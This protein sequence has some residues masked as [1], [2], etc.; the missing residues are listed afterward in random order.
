[1]SVFLALIGGM[2]GSAL[3]VIIPPLLHLRVIVYSNEAIQKGISK[4][5]A[6]K[7][8]L[9]ILVGVFL[10]VISTYVSFVELLTKLGETEASG[11]GS[12]SLVEELPSTT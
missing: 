9:I 5:H 4:F 12:S 7:D 10:G 8:V 1:M 6:T 11:S 3:A 2:G